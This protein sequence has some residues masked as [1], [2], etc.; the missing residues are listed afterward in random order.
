VHA[1][2]V[3]RAELRVAVLSPNFRGEV[4]EA[5]DR[6]ARDLADGLL[7]RGHFPC[8]ITGHDG[9]VARSVE[10][11]LPIVRVPRLPIEGR[12]VRRRLEDHLTHVP[13][14]YLALRGGRYDVAH[15][16]HQTDALAAARWS[17][18]TGG[19]SVFTYLG[20]PD[21][22]ELTRRR[23]R[24]DIML[25]AVKGV[26][27]VVAVSQAAAEAFERALGVRA[28]VIHPGVDLHRFRPSARRL[29]EPTIFC[30]AVPDASGQR[31]ATLVDAFALVRRARP[32]AQLLIRRPADPGFAQELTSSGD[33]VELIDDAEIRRR[34]P[35]LHSQ[36][37]VSAQPWLGDWLGVAMVEAMACGTPAVATRSLGMHEIVDRPEVGCLYDG[38]SSDGR[39][40]PLADALL[41]ALELAED[42]ATAVACRQRAEMFS[43]E[44]VT[45]RYLDLYAELLA[46]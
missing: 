39:P 29:E 13:F 46:T 35:E 31:V 22:E 23:R 42:P 45:E 14:S 10:D 12:L 1:I 7:A 4:L 21:R 44:D 6:V 41:Q 37:W 36:A 2:P 15:A 26:S 33:G 25:S 28:R 20:V 32:R 3:R 18:V 43:A 11:G 19:P 5:G 38:S 9:R 30:P 16:I 27:A 40:E 8:L 24:L 17:A 34:R